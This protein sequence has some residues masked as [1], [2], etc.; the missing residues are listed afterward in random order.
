MKV[1]RGFYRNF[2]EKSNFLTPPQFF[3]SVWGCFL[4]PS[5]GFGRGFGLIRMKRWK[6][7]SGKVFFRPGAIF[8]VFQKYY[9]K[10]GRPGSWQ[11][12]PGPAASTGFP[13]LLSAIAGLY[14]FLW[15]QWALYFPLSTSGGPPLECDRRVRSES[16]IGECD[17]RVRSECAIGV[18]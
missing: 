12:A 18:R 1:Y 6:N 3:F 8:G 7:N 14:I 5:E 11:P 17:R 9:P 2:I 13:E 16:A 10:N 4:G 15:L